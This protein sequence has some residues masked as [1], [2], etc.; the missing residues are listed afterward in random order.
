MPPRRTVYDGRV[1][2][3]TLGAVRYDDAMALERGGNIMTCSRVRNCRFDCFLKERY[4]A[5]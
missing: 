1:P 3:C 2:I 4:R 5:L